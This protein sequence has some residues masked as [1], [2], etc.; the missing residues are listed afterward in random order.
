MGAGGQPDDETMSIQAHICFAA[1]GIKNCSDTEPEWCRCCR[2]LGHPGE[3]RCACGHRW[4]TQPTPAA[5]RGPE[6]RRGLCRRVWDLLVG[7]VIFVVLY[8]AVVIG[9][10]VTGNL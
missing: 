3:H 5:A 1:H 10:L 9:Q 8:V 6:T 4:D 7:A 2:G